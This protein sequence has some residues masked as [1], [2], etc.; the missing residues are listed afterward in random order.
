MSIKITK[1]IQ[2]FW[3]NFCESNAKYHYLIDSKFEAWSFGDKPEYASELAQLV[4]EGKKTATCSLLKDYKGNE[5]QMPKVGTY[6]L[7]CD[8]GN[9][10]VAI[11]YQ[12][13]VFIQKFSE[14]NEEFAY[15]EGE[16]DRTLKYWR[17]EHIRFFS[18]YT[19]FNEELDIVCERFKVVYK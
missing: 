13:K 11:I 1:E 10:P 7:L 5:D 17:E 12:T 9:K 4:I 19:D 3:N 15:H 16:G 14:I 18:Q 2:H 6:S 8:G